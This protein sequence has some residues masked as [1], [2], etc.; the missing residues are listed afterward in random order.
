MVEAGFSTM[1]F[2]IYDIKDKE[3]KD[4][5]KGHNLMGQVACGIGSKFWLLYEIRC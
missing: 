3:A 5:F 2:V 1:A 4:L